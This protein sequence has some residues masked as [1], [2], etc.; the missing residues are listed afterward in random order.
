M[1]KQTDFS[2]NSFALSRALVE[3]AL[4]ELCLTPKPGL[5][6]RRDNGSHPDL[7]F[8]VMER[9]VMLLPQYYEELADAC[10]CGASTA[11]YR[12]IGLSAEKRMFSACGTNTHKGY[13]FLSGLV[14]ISSM[15]FSE[16]R[17][18]LSR[19]AMDFFTDALPVSNGSA[20][21]AA[22]GT[23]GI[24]GE[25]LSGLPSVF[26]AGLPAMGRRPADRGHYA[27]GCIMEIAEDTTSFHRCGENGLS[28]I[29]K[30]GEILRKL[31]ESGEDHTA[32]LA[33]RNN[34]YRQM[35]LTMGGCA[36]LLA[37]TYAFDTVGYC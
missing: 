31:I 1:T 5:V 37:L 26:E 25:C 2:I 24:I 11:E 23:G 29:R 17:D 16:M 35:N 14:L 12:K 21:R 10:L 33:E 30:D 6:D 9:S 36:D 20:V 27:L 15:L 22:Y 18:G 4:C 28:V 32:W 34:V 13:I 7:T 3:G 8:G 19:L